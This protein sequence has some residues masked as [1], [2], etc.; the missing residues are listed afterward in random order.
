VRRFLSLALLLVFCAG[1]GCGGRTSR[2]FTVGFMP[3]LVGIPYFN[4]CK[5]GAEE[6]AT[7]LTIKLVYNGPR[8]ADSN[9]Q[10]NLL[11]QWVASGSYDCLCVACNDPDLVANSL[12]NAR[13]NGLLVVTFDADSPA[14]S[15]STWPPTMRWPRRWSMPWPRNWDPNQKEKSAS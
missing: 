4:A 9:E 15:L 14:I 5:R 1:V 3:K 10:T 7:E 2:P 11:D 12:R 6:A 13:K 8:A